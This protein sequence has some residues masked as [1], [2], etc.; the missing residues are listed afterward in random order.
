MPPSRMTIWSFSCA[1]SSKMAALLG[2]FSDCT[3][4][5]NNGPRHKIFGNILRNNGYHSSGNEILYN[6]M[7][8]EQLE[9]EIY[10]DQLSTQD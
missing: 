3:A 9:T 6:G 8:G 4:F 5:V 7:T 2:G 1:L 10:F